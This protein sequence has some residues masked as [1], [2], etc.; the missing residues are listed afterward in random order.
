MTVKVKYMAIKTHR[1]G[2]DKVTQITVRFYV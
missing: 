1:P 2:C